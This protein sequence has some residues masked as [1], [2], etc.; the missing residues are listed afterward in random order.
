M[1]KVVSNKELE[2]NQV[3]ESMELIKQEHLLELE[4]MRAQMAEQV[5]KYNQLKLEKFTEF[6]KGY[7][8]EDANIDAKYKIEILQKQIEEMRKLSKYQNY[9][10][11][12]K[13]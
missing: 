6:D 12:M 13:Q 2:I 9:D 5:T 11:S 10:V 8:A 1:E 4:N 7:L 3:R